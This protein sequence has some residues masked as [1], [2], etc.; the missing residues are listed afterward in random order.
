[1]Q[2]FWVS[3][4]VG[5]IK[6]INLTFKTLV[7]A[8]LSLALLLIT[9]GSAL[10]FFGFR[11][12][13]EYDPA[14]ARKLGNLH[15]AVELENLHALY[16]AK[17]F[18][19]NNQLEINRNKIKELE[20]LNQKLALMATPVILGKEK[21]AL[22]SVGGQ[23]Q[24]IKNH[25]SKSL[26]VLFSQSSLDLKHLNKRLDQS[27]AKTK[28]YVDWLKSKPI[29]LPIHGSL[30]LASGFGTRIDP[31]ELNPSFHA[32]LDFSSAKGTP[33]YA[34]AKGKVTAAGWHASYGNQVL[35]DHADG[36]STRYAHAEKLYVTP[37]MFV[38]QSS[39][40]GAVGSTGRSTGPHL[41]YEVMKNGER[42]DPA[43]FF[44]GLKH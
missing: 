2:L 39:L 8:L 41:H 30:S 4:A 23:Y 5:Q 13:I 6:S 40:L 32:G 10:Q 15:T 12:A 27:I 16:K 21:L 18:E 25:E 37:G 26:L 44:L 20:A 31:F 7:F 17:L 22:L 9:L 29:S 14:I 43:Q 24:P 19:V 38:E 28:Q 36:F 34:A 42:I 11:M 3:G 33:F 35:I 1:M